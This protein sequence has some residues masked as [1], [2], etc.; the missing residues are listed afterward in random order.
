MIIAYDAG[1]FQQS[2]N[3]GIFNVSVGFRTPPPESPPMSS[4]FLSPIPFSE[5]CER[6]R[7]PR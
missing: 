3:G 2:I 6:M 5:R 7:C 4:S 1:A